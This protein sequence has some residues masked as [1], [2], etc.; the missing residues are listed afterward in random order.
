M[1]PRTL[2]R[3]GIICFNGD[4]AIERFNVSK[5]R[6]RAC[7]RR[8]IRHSYHDVPVGGAIR[9]SE[10]VFPDHQY[11]PAQNRSAATKRRG[12]GASPLLPDYGQI[13][14][15]PEKGQSRRLTRLAKPHFC[16]KFSHHHSNT[17]L[18]NKFRRISSTVADEPVKGGDEWLTT[19]GGLHDH[20][21][22]GEC[23][24]QR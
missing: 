24:Q 12:H 11:V 22:A 8:D 20:A 21:G 9:A 15:F 6:T 4:N 18:H 7:V 13:V 3:R 16:V 17:D 2:P 19:R 14:W 5:Q 1:L 23:D 10:S